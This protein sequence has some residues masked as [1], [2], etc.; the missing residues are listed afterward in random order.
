MRPRLIFEATILTVAVLCAAGWYL[1]ARSEHRRDAQSNEELAFK[2]VQIEALQETI[3]ELRQQAEIA[4]RHAA[5]EK[6]SLQALLTEMHAMRTAFRRE[7]TGRLIM[8]FY[9]RDNSI[10]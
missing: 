3:A 2:A 6:S 1:Q 9:P 10:D 4:E 8:H 7:P 5:S